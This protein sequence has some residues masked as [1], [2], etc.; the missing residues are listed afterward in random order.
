M[1][2][3]ASRRS[4]NINAHQGKAARLL[5]LNPTTLGAKIKHYRIQLGHPAFFNET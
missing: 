2:S 4:K 5:N 3:A 1:S